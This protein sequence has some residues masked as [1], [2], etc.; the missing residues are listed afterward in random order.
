[1]DKEGG[2]QYVSPSYR[3]E[4][5]YA[6]EDLLGKSAFTWIHPDDLEPVR[7][8]FQSLIKTGITQEVSFRYQSA[9]GEYLWFQSRGKPV[10]DSQGE[11][12]GV[13]V[14]NRNITE[15][16]RMEEALRQTEA[17][18]QTLVEQS[19]QGLIVIEGGR[20]VFANSAF[21]DI[22]GYPV[23]ELQSLSPE[24]VTALI[25][26]ED[27]A[28]VWGNFRDRLAG[29]AAP[30]RYQ[31]RGVR[32]EGAVCWLEMAAS[33]I[34]YGGKPAI[35][36]SIVDI[37]ERKLAEEALKQANLVVENSPVVLFRW[38][39]TKGWPVEMVSQ[40]VSQFGYTPEELLSGAVPFAAMVYPDDLDRVAG[41]VQEYSASGVDRFQQEYRIVAKDGKVCWVDDR[42]VV[43]RNLDGQI[44]CYQ[45]ILVDITERKVTATALQKREKELTLLTD[46]MIDMISYIDRDRVIRYMSPSIRFDPGPRPGE[47]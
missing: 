3:D 21:A 36:C 13:V 20:I 33:R 40:N 23:E 41:E 15:R 11:L 14:S 26:P 35:Q 39:A 10:R 34:T 43:E 1:M 18:Y 5:G 9:T 28:L 19:V 22:S 42:T 4:L 45:G 32:K 2:F 29:K 12:I 25:H 38:K 6:P 47:R 44:V 8:R 24:Q 17:K 27:Q 30:P 7:E 37:T 16:K 46:N 31:Y